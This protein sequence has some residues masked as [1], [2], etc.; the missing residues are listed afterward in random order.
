MT[1]LPPLLRKLR[2]PS[3]LLATLLM[4]AACATQP[5]RPPV[6]IGSGQPR[7][8][9]V[10]GE[11]VT[12]EPG[13]EYEYDDDWLSPIARD[14]GGLTPEF[15][16]GRD[17]KRAAVLLPFT[18]PTASVRVEA[19]SMLA[20][21]E[22]ALF[23]FGGP[24]FLIMPMDTA[25]RTSTAEARADEAIRDGADLILG[26]LF[27]ANVGAVKEAA[28]RESV[29]IIAFSN[30]RSVAGGGA[31]LASLMPEEEVVRVMGY[32]ATR[33]TRTFVFLGPDSAYGRQVEAAMRAEAARNGWY[34]AATSFYSPGEG[35]S[36]EASYIAGVI[37]QQGG[38]ANERIGVVIPERGVTLLSIAPLLIVNG[39]DLGRVRLL[40]TSIWDDPSIWREPAL[41]GAL[42]A[43]RDP[44]NLAAFQDSYNRIYGRRPSELAAAAYD[45]AALAISLSDDGRVMHSEMTDPNGY[46]GVNGLFRFRLDGTAERG[47][48]VKQIRESGA[49]VVEKGINTFPP[50]GS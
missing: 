3:L 17:V 24:D 45:A 21:I 26:P 30:D 49:E 44:D 1:L 20:G 32:A 34:I 28:Q 42:F 35:A 39:I 9:P 29:P 18:H 13:E 36:A 46:M 41:E 38:S 16:R 15:M 10:T 31:Y 2:A 50:G 12:P 47:L 4:A 43:T 11:T 40:G 48:A 14:D 6:S 19:E 5:A 25:G 8:D 7:V 27:A 23:E 22:L 33:G 37:R